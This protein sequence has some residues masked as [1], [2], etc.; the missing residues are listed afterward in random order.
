[1]PISGLMLE[2]WYRFPTVV[3]PERLY[4]FYV[5]LLAAL[6]MNVSVVVAPESMSDLS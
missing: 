4:E 2:G 5:T 3:R 6:R 1:M